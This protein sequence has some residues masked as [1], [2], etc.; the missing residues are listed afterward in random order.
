MAHSHEHNHHNHGGENIK[1][2]F[3]INFAFCILE[4][5]GGF[6]INSVAI[7]SNALHD[8]G[9][10]ISLLMALY[11]QKVSGKKRDSK[12]SYGYRRFSLLGA[13]INSAIL[14]IGS[15]FIIIESIKR[16]SEPVVP[17]AKGMILFAI[18]GLAVNLVALLRLRKGS[19]M[20]ERVVSLHFLED[21]LG[22]ATV[23]V[24][25]IVMLFF[26]IPILDPILSIA[27]AGFILLNIYKNINS[28]FKVIL[29][30][31]P[32]NIDEGKI[33]KTIL[34]T[35]GVIDVHDLHIWTMD[36]E[37]NILTAHV[38]ADEHIQTLEQTDALKAGIKEKLIAL[39]INHPTIEIE[40][41]DSLCEGDC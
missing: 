32:E 18:I 33:Q 13:L 4:F 31:T 16:F 23:L 28:S 7:I 2:A 20:N 30:G 1:A 27:I 29:Q 9:D 38:V 36:G 6:F 3:I 15:I 37:Y 8:L 26:N 17:Q 24:S 21:I 5:I 22:W 11:F 10:S 14:L 34:K 40:H 35:E 19:S 41:T 12:Y 39:G 25:A